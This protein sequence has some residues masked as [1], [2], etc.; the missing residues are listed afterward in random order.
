MKIRH[1]LYIA[2]AALLLTGSFFLPN[3]VAGIFD[4]RR[5]DNLI[6]IDAQSI[7]YSIA[8]E[9]NLPER[10]KFTTS[11]NTEIMAIKTGQVM[12]ADTAGDR[13][14]AELARFFA[15]GPFKIS[16]NDCTIEEGSATLIIDSEKQSVSMITWEFRLY[17]PAGNEV[18]VLIDDETGVIL[19]LY[20]SEKTDHDTS[21]SEGDG[22]SAASNDDL[23]YS[24]RRLTEMMTTYYSHIV[25][26]GDYMFSSSMAYYRADL[27]SGGEV[28]PLYGVVRPTGFTMNER[29]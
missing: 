11:P 20:L 1:Y 15:G 14:E 17:D 9:L 5:L 12:D 8:Y 16:I 3:A 6:T 7:D 26:L 28:I 19:R 24:A 10:I 18:S 4:A 27:I 22:A 25:L 2:A 29:P 21:G 13:A 23:Y